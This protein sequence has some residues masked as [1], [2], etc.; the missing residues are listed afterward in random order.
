[1]VQK[2]NGKERVEVKQ[3]EREK[4]R[5]RERGEIDLRRRKL[6][7]LNVWTDSKPDK[8]KSFRALNVTAT[9]S[10]M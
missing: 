10:I 3:R 5:A 9:S 8:K 2:V 7:A 1:M 4:G 6:S